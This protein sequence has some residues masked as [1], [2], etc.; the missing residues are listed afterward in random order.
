VNFNYSATTIDKP[1][2]NQTPIGNNIH[3]ASILGSSNCGVHHSGSGSGKQNSE[4][5]AGVKCSGT[6]VRLLAI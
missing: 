6:M 4:I 3:G 5:P 1:T 2:R